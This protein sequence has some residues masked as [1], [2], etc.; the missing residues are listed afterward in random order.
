MLAPERPSVR[1]PPVAAK[2]S[3]GEVLA[4]RQQ[5]SSAPP[6]FEGTMVMEHA[7]LLGQ[8]PGAPQFPAPSARPPPVQQVQAQA[9]PQQ[10]SQPPIQYSPQPPA[11]Q[12]SPQPP[13][14]HS[15]QPPMQY[16]HGRV[17]SPHLSPSAPQVFVPAGAPAL[18]RALESGVDGAVDRGV[19][20]PTSTGTLFGWIAYT[21]P[22][23]LATL[24]V[25]SLA[26][27]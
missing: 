11:V 15:P 24:A 5:K 6:P 10:F 2:R 17:Y 20:V 16:G 13:M 22:L 23:L 19:E 12:Y 27:K 18:V 26:L 7:P 3:A 9:R 8:Q 4:Q 21:A 14:V 25:A 1:P